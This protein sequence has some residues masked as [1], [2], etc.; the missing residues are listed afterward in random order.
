MCACVWVEFHFTFH[1]LWIVIRM[2]LNEPHWRENSMFSDPMILLSSEFT[3]HSPCIVFR[4]SVDTTGESPLVDEYVS[5]DGS[6][7]ISG[8]KIKSMGKSINDEGHSIHETWL[9]RLGNS[10]SGQIFSDGED[11]PDWLILSL[12]RV[13]LVLSQIRLDSKCQ[14]GWFLHSIRR[15]TVYWV[16]SRQRAS[17]W[18][19]RRRENLEKTGLISSYLLHLDLTFLLS[20]TRVHSPFSAF[21]SASGYQNYVDQFFVSLPTVAE[22]EKCQPFLK[23]R[24]RESFLSKVFLKNL[25]LFP[26]WQKVPLTFS[27]PFNLNLTEL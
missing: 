11:G 10:N 22:E 5:V 15:C 24:V 16:R 6:G 7:L 13:P 4:K 19:R 23:T 2:G 27:S 26:N 1:F 17:D 12:S 8:R 9:E 18:R 3:T 14:G 20:S 25:F 21:P